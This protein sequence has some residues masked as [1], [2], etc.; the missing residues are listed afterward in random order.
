[1]HFELRLAAAECDEHPDSDELALLDV[2]PGR[3]SLAEAKRDDVMSQYRRRVGQG[4]DA[5]S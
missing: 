1:V 4:V 5:W 3:R 2:G